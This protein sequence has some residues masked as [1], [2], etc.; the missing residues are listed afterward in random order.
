MVEFL[1]SE[2]NFQLRVTSG[3]EVFSIL[4]TFAPN[5]AKNVATDGPAKTVDASIIF[6]VENILKFSNYCCRFEINHVK[7]GSNESFEDHPNFTLVI[8]NDPAMGLSLKNDTVSF[9]S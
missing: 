4:I 6:K 1:S 9:S 3:L 8:V 2:G 5:S 7:I